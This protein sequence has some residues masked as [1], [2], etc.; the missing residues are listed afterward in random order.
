[1]AIEIERL[2][3]ASARAQVDKPGPRSTRVAFRRSSRVGPRD[4]MFFTER[5]SLLL[6]T[7]VP[8]HT[9]LDSLT[10]QKA[11]G[12]LGPLL[13][14]I[15][16]AVVEGN[17]FANA[18]REHPA[19]FPREYVNL[20]DAAEA[21][22]F[23]PKALDRLRDMEERRQDL[24]SAL[25][26]AISYPAFLAVFSLAVVV[27]VLVVVFPKFDELF[28]MLGDEL[29]ATTRVLMASSTFLT[30]FWPLVL[31]ALGAAGFGLQRWLTSPEGGRALDRLSLGTP[32]LRDVVVQLNVV[33]LLR[34]LALSLENRVNVVDALRAAQDSVRSGAFRDF[35]RRV[36][37]G[38]QEGRGIAR[39]FES[40][41]LLPDLVKQLVA[42][43]EESGRLGP[44]MHRLADFYER[45]WR[46]SIGIAAKIAEPAML[47]VMGCVVG[48]IVGSLILPIFKV[49]RVVH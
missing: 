23:L 30:R 5:L 46:R 2:P 12:A 26:S 37:T 24:H 11:S 41:P 35:L 17:S 42:T 43:G 31:G 27:F 19:V 10:R 49:S 25:S 28:E 16:D 14:Q 6:D 40:E 1:M 33:Q 45:E 22:G 34:V 48:L 4:R 13:A 44:V 36:E 20:V 47:V 38:V 3:A 9:A 8:I 39:G 18:L 32:V 29:P 21:G 7:G 15:R